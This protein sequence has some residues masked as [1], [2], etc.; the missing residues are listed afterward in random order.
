MFSTI[1]FL[2]DADTLVAYTAACLVLFVTPGPD[3]SLIL[4]K[5]IGGGRS[6]GM[7]TVLGTSTG[8]IV[9]SVLAALGISALVA[10][11]PTAFLALKAVGAVYLLWLAIDAIRH[12]SSLS[13]AATATGERLRFW[14]TYL[15]G[16]TVNLSNPKIILFF[17]TFLPQFIATGD[18][19]AAGKLLFL[20]IYFVIF[21]M[22]L[23]VIMILGAERVIGSLQANPRMMRTI[24]WVF[25]GVFGAFA[26]KILAT[27]SR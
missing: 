13:P 26:V 24:D 15:L 22:P 11:S 25:A 21:T 8:C 18:P 3:M 6:A 4:A 5:T 12:G 23:A 17:V 10:A 1:T 20:G 7:A 16:L 14:R 19:A 2:P 9:H 27:Q